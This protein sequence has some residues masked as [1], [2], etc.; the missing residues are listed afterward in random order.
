M[1]A[2]HRPGS[3]S[4]TKPCPVRGH[5]GV[6][7]KILQS[8]S[9]TLAVILFG[10]NMPGIAES[11]EGSRSTKGIRP[12]IVADFIYAVIESDRTLYTTHIVD[13]MQ[14]T[15]TVVAG[16]LEVPERSAPSGSDVAVNRI[17]SEGERHRPR[18]SSGKPSSYLPKKWSCH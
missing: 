17:S 8:L 15:G 3:D 16:R 12:E 13:R 5:E 10:I 1:C 14:E 18:V 2:G 4:V 9:F 11:E 6:V 7:M